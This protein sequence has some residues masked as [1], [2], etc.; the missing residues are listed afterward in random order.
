MS[1]PEKSPG[2]THKETLLLEG[3]NQLFAHGYHGMT[4]GGVLDVA[5]VPKG[6]FYHHFASKEAFAVAVI[7]RYGGFHQHQLR[8]A[9]ASSTLS[10]AELLTGYFRELVRLFLGSGY[11]HGDLV[12]KLATEVTSSSPPLRA[13]LAEL[14]RDW[15]RELEDLLAEGVA[16]GDVREDLSVTDLSAAVHA[17]F[18][19]AFVVALST[20]DPEAL[21]AITSAVEDVITGNS[22]PDSAL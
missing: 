8:K 19:G 20:R 5:G 13:K 10:T 16:A 15:R 7:D 9:A 3:M 22:A 1:E 21:E 2:S 6:S 17:L 12:G 18:D 11:R 4:I 14:V